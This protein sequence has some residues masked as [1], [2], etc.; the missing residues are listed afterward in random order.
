MSEHSA[1]NLVVLMVCE[2]SCYFKVVE[3]SG[4]KDDELTVDLKNGTWQYRTDRQRKIGEAM[5]V[6]RSHEHRGQPIGVYDKS[7][8]SHLDSMVHVAID[9]SRAGTGSIFD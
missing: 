9:A 1:E 2:N 6:A 8:A 7:L 4:I 5:Y 3:F